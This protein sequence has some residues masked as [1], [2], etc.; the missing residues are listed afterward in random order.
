MEIIAE[1]DE[2]LHAAQLNRENVLSSISMQ[3]KTQLLRNVMSGHT[4]SSRK[5][6]DMAC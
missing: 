4:H 2:Y 6:P 1:I 5:G 3:I